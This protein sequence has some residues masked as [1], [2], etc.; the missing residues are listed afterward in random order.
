[1][2]ATSWLARFF[3]AA[4]LMLFIG[5]NSRLIVAA[6]ILPRSAQIELAALAAEKA[7]LK[8]NDRKLDSGLRWALRYERDRN[9]AKVLP[10]F[11]F[12][13]PDYLGRVYVD[14]RLYRATD[15]AAMRLWLQSL[16]TAEIQSAARDELRAMI[17]LADLEAIA[18][19]AEVKRVQRAMPALTSRSNPLSKTSTAHFSKALNVTQG[20]TAHRVL[21]ARNTLGLTGLGQK[22]CVLSDSVDH[23]GNVQAAGDLPRDIEILAGQSGLGNGFS[24]EGTA[25]L[26]IVHDIAPDAALAFATAFNGVAGFAQ[27]IL[28]LRSVTGCNIIVDDIFYFDESPFQDGPIAQAVNAVTADGALYFSS[29]G[30]EGNVKNGT[31]GVYEG[32]FVDGGSLAA[33]PGG[34]VN[35]FTASLG[36]SNQ[37]RVTASGFA[38]TLFWSDALGAADNDYDLFVMSPDLLHVLDA[39]TDVQDGD[40]DPFEITGQIFVDDRIVVLKNPGAAERYLH[41]NGLRGR[42]NLATNGQTKG[43]SAAENAFSVAAVNVATA[44][45]GAFAG[46]DANPV[47]SFSSDGP[48]RVFYHADGSLANIGNPSLLADG[49][50]LRNKPDITAA[51]GVATAT[52]GFSA[53]FGTSAAAPHAAAIAALLKQANPALASAEIRAA[54][55]AS[56]LDIEDKGND[57]NSGHGIVMADSALAAIAATPVARLLVSSSSFTVVDGDADA[58]I[59]PG[60]TFDLAIML[61]NIGAATASAMSA[62]ITSSSSGVTIVRALSN[63]PDAMAGMTVAPLLPFRIRIDPTVACGR[64]IVIHLSVDFAGGSTSVSPLSLAPQFLRIGALDIPMVASYDGPAIAIP[65]NDPGGVAVDVDIAAAGIHIGDVDL[66]FDGNLCNTEP[67]NTEVGLSHTFIGDLEIRLRSPAGATVDVLTRPQAGFGD[68][69]GNHLCQTL[70]DDEA[71]L[72]IQDATP[73]SAPFSGNF[74]PSTLL[75][76]LD[77]ESAIGTWQLQVADH[78]END[79]G[80][81]RAFS[82]LITPALCDIHAPNLL[83]ADSFE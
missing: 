42:F 28:D 53:F 49:G 8:P 36:S 69:N 20:V 54:L 6:E 29:A 45:Q 39:S 64:E 70:F 79:L 17:R 44:T 66:R 35:L 43:H 57:I 41:L 56:A 74:R 73:S 50:W 23:L 76:T 61:D 9:I 14:V 26:E 59:E 32:N 2:R 3:S 52:P 83:L 7:S 33:L 5:F 22:I 15:L 1:M 10:K 82:V 51:D 27:N 25:M 37:I 75:N 80:Q 13:E 38:A 58:V 24:G 11:R 47:E 34:T 62:S 48:R 4:S 81:I 31:A 12:I 65:D 71:S 16:A 19:R 40:D 18:A 30:N 72:S 46:G 67:G 78:A 68:S 60:E 77:G 55:I 63:Y 21:T